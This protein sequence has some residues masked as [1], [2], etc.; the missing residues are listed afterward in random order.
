MVSS[1][2]DA[3][4]LGTPPVLRDHSVHVVHRRQR[5]CKLGVP[6]QRLVHHD[7]VE[8]ADVCRMQ[9]DFREQ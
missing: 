2:G 9:Q 4:I 1:R 5:V 8:L 6:P 7:E 3:L